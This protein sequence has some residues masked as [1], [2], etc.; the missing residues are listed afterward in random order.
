MRNQLSGED[1]CLLSR[2]QGRPRQA[3]S[4]AGASCLE[5]SGRSVDVR[6]QEPGAS[7]TRR[8]LLERL[9]G[10]RGSSQ[11]AWSEF[12]RRYG[13]K[14]YGWCLRWNLQD[15][16]A[17]DVTQ[18][19]LLKLA[20]R[21]RE[22]RY[23]PDRSFRGWLKTV[24]HNAW[25]DFIASRQSAALGAGGDLA[26]ERLDSIAARDD[27]SCS[28]EGVFDLEILEIAIQRVR[29]RAATHTWTAFSMTAIEGKE[30][31]EVARRLG[32]KIARVYAARSTIQQRL[33]EECR[34]LESAQHPW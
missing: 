3:C 12:V 26:A 2:P 21:M 7:A 6:M 15:A 30:A 23:D 11:A 9:A 18:I 10:S 24:T 4:F 16:D 28:L 34:R 20:G 17:Q 5:E 14:I 29:L 13:R 27:L 33:Q 19:V 1:F 32:M 25:R 8:T 22:F 31:P